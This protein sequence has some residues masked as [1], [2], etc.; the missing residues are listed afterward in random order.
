M[1]APTT[2]A[3]PPRG[4]RR[5]LYGVALLELPAELAAEGVR[6]VEAAGSEVRL[7]GTK[8]QASFPLEANFARIRELAKP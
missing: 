1:G 5:L 7:R 8:A 6:E 4:A 2:I 3:L